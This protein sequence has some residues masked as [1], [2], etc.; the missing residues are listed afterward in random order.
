M[1]LDIE[2]LPYRPCVGVML[3]NRK[4]E[5]MVGRRRASEDAWQMPQG[6]IDKGESP[7]T[8]ALRELE[9]EIGT[10]NARILG[11]TRDWLMYD[12]P[13]ELVPMTWGGKY[14]GQRQKWF[15]LEFLGSDADITPERVSHPEFDAWQWVAPDRLVALA[16]TFK[17]HIYESVVAEFAPLIERLRA[18][19]APRPGAKKRG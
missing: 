3:L 17:R 4:G 7:E 12:L 10:A 8:A 6:G 19:S 18:D 2:R 16:V 1:T 15:A 14:R 13:P 5:V 11:E 9:E